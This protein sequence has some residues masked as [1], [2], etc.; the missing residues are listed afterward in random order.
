MRVKTAGNN[1]GTRPKMAD[2]EWKPPAR[3][4]KSGVHTLDLRAQDD[5]THAPLDD[6]AQRES[7]PVGARNKIKT[8]Q[9]DL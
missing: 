6:F 4:L 9:Y 3:K 5:K 7:R 2:L 1:V 8:L